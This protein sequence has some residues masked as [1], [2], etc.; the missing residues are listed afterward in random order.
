MKKI[1]ALVLFVFT[2]MI[3]LAQTQPSA[4]SSAHLTFKGV[5][6]D[7]T[8]REYI[9]KMQSNGFTHVAT[10][11]G[12]ALM[13]GDFASYKNCMVGVSTLKQKD[14]VSN[15]TVIFPE[16]DTWSSLLSNYTSLKELLTEKYGKATREVEKFDGMEP[17]DDN[18]RMHQVR[19]DR[20]KY[21]TTFETSKGSIELSIEHDDS[22][23]CFV[24]LS[25][26]DRINGDI[27]KAKAKDDL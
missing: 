20:C 16:R 14:L 27:V 13:K 7:G 15:V 2:A 22:K 21:F 11:N 9:L 6:I 8:L 24:R 17:D 5:P 10:E 25:Y 3:S 23:G 19:F 12:I 18:S 1:I 4:G 26:F